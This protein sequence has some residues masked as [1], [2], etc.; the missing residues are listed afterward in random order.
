MTGQRLLGWAILIAYRLLAWTWRKT[1]I[2]HAS[3]TAAHGRAIIFAHWHGDELAIAHL[4]RAWR[5]ATMTSTSRDGQLM[6][7]VVRGLGGVTA[8]GSSSRGAVGAL[9]GLV[10]LC[11]GGHNASMAVD[12][13]RGP[14][15]QVK[16]GV[17]QLAR[18][19]SGVVTPVGVAASAGYVFARS[20][21]RAHIPYPFARVVVYFGPVR[22]ARETDGGYP[23]ADLGQAIDRA[24][25][26][27]R[28]LLDGH[29]LDPALD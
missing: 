29:D 20:W 10:R 15:H 27:A 11:R 25:R 17:F 21:N 1:V 2:A 24:S 4:A 18:L 6:D 3:V 28:R 22:A 13:P 16:P 14:Y 26:Q 5:I 9:K 7:F 19:T 12:G 8:R 23:T